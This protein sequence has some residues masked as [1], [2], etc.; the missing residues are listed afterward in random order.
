MNEVFSTSR[1]VEPFNGSLTFFIFLACY[2]RSFLYKGMLLPSFITK[3]HAQPLAF[4]SCFQDFFFF[5]M[6]WDL[7][8]D[9]FFVVACFFFAAQFPWSLGFDIKLYIDDLI[10]VFAFIWW[11]CISLLAT[12]L[13]WRMPS[14][15]YILFLQQQ[16]FSDICLCNDVSIRIFNYATMLSPVL[17]FEVV[18]ALVSAMKQY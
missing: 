8:P 10:K 13:Q 14:C 12:F 6:L 2:L 17:V 15:C 4:F 7:F 5:F 1:L 18:L 16:S 3:A 11:L 9:K